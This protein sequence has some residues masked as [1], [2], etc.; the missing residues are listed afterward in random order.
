MRNLVLHFLGFVL[1][2]QNCRSHNQKFR[3]ENMCN[4]K[5]I[6]LFYADFLYSLNLD[7]GS[8]LWTWTRTTV[9]LIKKLYMP[10]EDNFLETRHF[11]I[12]LLLFVN[13]YRRSY[14]FWTNLKSFTML[15]I[16]I[17]LLKNSFCK[18][19]IIFRNFVFINTLCIDVTKD[20][21]VN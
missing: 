2:I 13:C 16:Y 11:E 4:C 18:F 7:V 19:W 12:Q 5:A 3:L 1:K 21:I 20:S 8:W 14:S 10:S 15:K 17:I 9:N 6:V